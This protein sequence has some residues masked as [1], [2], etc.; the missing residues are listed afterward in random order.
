[1][2]VIGPSLNNSTPARPSPPIL[3]S[4]DRTI[5]VSS[6][7]EPSTQRTMSP[8]VLASQ[9]WSEYEDEGPGPVPDFSVPVPTR[10]LPAWRTYDSEEMSR[11]AKEGHESVDAW[12]EAEEAKRAKA[13]AS[14]RVSETASP[15]PEEGREKEKAE[16]RIVS[17]NINRQLSVLETLLNSPNLH[18]IDI[19]LLQEPPRTL[20]SLPPTWRLAAPLPP[21]LPAE[22]EKRTFI[23]SIALISSRLPPSAIQQ[24]H[25]E[26][27][28][29]VALDLQ[30]EGQESVRIVGVYNPHGGDDDHGAPLLL[31]PTLLARTPQ[32]D[33]TVVAG[34]FNLRHQEWEPA[35]TSPPSPA[36]E[37]ASSLF[38][39]LALS[40][41]L[42]PSTTTWHSHNGRD[43][44]VMDL[45]WGDLRTEND[46]VSCGVAVDLDAGSDHRPIRLTLPTARP[47]PAPAAPRWAFRKT[48]PETALLA[49]AL[50]S[51]LIPCT[52]TL[53]TSH[54]IDQEAERLTLIL[55]YTRLAAVPQRKPPRPGKANPWWS[56]EVAEAS[57]AAQA[58]QNRRCELAK[59]VRAG[60]LDLAEMAAAA[61]KTARVLQ[62]RKKA[63][64]RRAKREA[65]EEEVR[66]AMSESIWK[67]VRREKGESASLPPPPPLKGGDGT[68]ATTPVAK[69]DLLLPHL[70]PPQ[71]P[72]VHEQGGEDHGGEGGE[73]RR[74]GGEDEANGG[75]EGDDDEEDDGAHEWPELREDEVNAA[76][77]SS[78]PFAAAGPDN[79][80]NALLQ[81]LYPHLR[82]RLIPLAAAALRLGHLPR[83]WRDAIGLVFRKPKK[84]D[85][86][87]PKAYR[88]ISF[89]RCV[90]KVL[91]KVVARRLGYLSEEGRVLAKNHIGGRRC[92]SVEDT[93]ACVDDTIRRQWRNGNL[94]VGLAIDGAAAFPSLRWEQL[95]K[96][97][98][99]HGVPR[100]ARRFI[101]SF[102]Q[103]RRI[104]LK[105]EDALLDSPAHGLPQGSALSPILYCLY[106]SEVVEAF[107]TTGSTAY[108]WIDD[109]NAF[110]WGRTAEE[111]VRT[112]NSR[113]PLIE[114][115]SRTHSSRFEP[116][117]SAA[118]LFAPPG[119]HHPDTLPPVRLCGVDVPFSP[120]LTMLGTEL[121]AHLSYAPHVAACAARA[122]MALNG[123]KALLSTK[124]GVTIALGRQ[125]VQGVVA[126]RLQYGGGVWWREGRSEG[127]VKVLRP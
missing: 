25:V 90:T 2:P 16:E 17:Y 9:S 42:P 83:P 33:R 67:M 12:I 64:I 71:A 117:K 23:R 89:E 99:K 29:V 77:F 37:A 79:I 49:F 60:R 91:E 74:R 118:V 94:V 4:R 51:R 69:L 1:M 82:L 76:L 6:A 3:P 108:G 112:L 65:G 92:R 123:V 97:M 110:A 55:Q 39:D 14:G 66:G 34:D 103:H 111:A 31:L 105:L 50:F 85:Y 68:Y 86:P 120:S 104:T 46:L 48:N 113:L 100:P 78:R 87:K 45:F 38:S 115:W 30:G 88:M 96:D 41:L 116:L 114:S 125:L 10:L 19:L 7:P 95:E 70:Q 43:D 27:T 47:P 53:V 21:P 54:D 57:K 20:P 32:T 81:M 15:E 36:A 59:K 80:P 24:H 84:P 58:A 11:L 93:L 52:R 119:K 126:P 61:K 127:L 98:K 8:T 22:G 121:D 107:E 44:G 73:R 40:L 106:N 101:S 75:E 35:R 18:H 5:S 122:Q 28:E 102:L 109:V 56:A 62:N 124:T 13:E 26:S 63:I 72:A